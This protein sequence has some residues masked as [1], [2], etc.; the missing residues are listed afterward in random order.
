[1]P[2]SGATKADLVYGDDVAPLYFDA[3]T[4]IDVRFKGNDMPAP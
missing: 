3:G 4:D 2:V 1:M